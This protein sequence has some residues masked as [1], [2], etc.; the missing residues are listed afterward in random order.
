MC[1]TRG[2][3]RARA[4]LQDS[5]ATVHRLVPRWAYLPGLPSAPGSY[6]PVPQDSAQGLWS[7]PPLSIPQQLCRSP[8]LR[9]GPYTSF[10]S[11][12]TVF[13]QELQGRKC[14]NKRENNPSS[15]RKMFPRH[16]YLYVL[17]WNWEALLTLLFCIAVMCKDALHL[18][19]LPSPIQ[20]WQLALII[21]RF[22]VM[23]CILANLTPSE[24]LPYKLFT[25]LDSLLH[26]DSS[27]SFSSLESYQIPYCSS[28]AWS[29]LVLEW[30]CLDIMVQHTSKY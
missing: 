28:A 27:F 5:R 21:N 11:P 14:S 13:N 8:S 4:G 6:L 3:L 12:E 20:L 7:G 26:S 2:E 9:A 15:P 17:D 29:F 30:T 23:M 10:I 25:V 18:C 1:P 19:A 16:F 24:R 22:S